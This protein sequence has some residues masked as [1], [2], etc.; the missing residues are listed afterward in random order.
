MVLDE[1]HRIKNSV[2]QVSSALR[3][4]KSEHRLILTG[5][6]LQNSLLEMWALLAWLYP[7]VFTDNTQ[8]LFKE[9]FDLGKGKVN[10]DTMDN[11]RS[12]LELIMLWR[13]KD[14][15]SV[16]LGLPPKEEILLFVP[17]TP[18]QKFWYTRLITRIDDDMLD[19]LFTNGNL[20]DMP[21]IREGAQA[22]EIVCKGE[23]L[24]TING[25]DKTNNMGK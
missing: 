10:M 7:G 13:M 3:T 17:L 18:I 15:P 23:H 21:A 19:A 20:K 9:S 25:L 11:I 8:T 4:I 6:P 2:T 1:G 5:T 12:L 16:S 14:S 22:L 24:D